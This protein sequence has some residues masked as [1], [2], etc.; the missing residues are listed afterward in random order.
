M[1]G[2]TPS[3]TSRF[4]GAPPYGISIASNGSAFLVGTF[5][6]DGA[7]NSVNLIALDA[8][9]KPTDETRIAASA[10][11][12]GPVIGSDGTDYLV[13][14]VFDRSRSTIDAHARIRSTTTLDGVPESVARGALLWTGRSYLAAA[15]ASDAS[16]QMELFGLGRSGA[17]TI[18]R[19]PLGSRHTQVNEPGAMAWSG[20][21]AL[22][23][24]GRGGSQNALTSVGSGWLSANADATSIFADD[25]DPER[26]S[27]MQV[28]PVIATSGSQDLAVWAEPTGIYPARIT[29]DGRSLDG[30]RSFQ[31]F[32]R[33]TAEP[34]AQHQRKGNAAGHL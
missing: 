23:S 20:T 5:A 11:G 6:Y 18:S 9:G 29:P 26:G 3:V 14:Y 13:L 2:R 24:R 4:I 33:D 7:S 34:R 15:T 31:G 27:N 12:D 28:A 25:H 1:E 8:N 16:Q 19:R 22:W 30:L 17:L 10:S 21:R 32:A